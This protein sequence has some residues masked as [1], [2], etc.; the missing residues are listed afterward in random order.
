MCVCFTHWP[1][2]G[3]FF[4]SL[5]RKPS[6]SLESGWIQAPYSSVH[7][8]PKQPLACWMMMVS[9][10][11]WLRIFKL[12]R[13][14]LHRLSD[15]V[16]EKNFS[17]AGLLIGGLYCNSLCVVRCKKIQ[18]KSPRDLILA[19]S[20]RI[21]LLVFESRFPWIFKCMNSSLNCRR[22]TACQVKPRSS[23]NSNSMNLSVMN[24]AF[25]IPLIIAILSHS[26]SHPLFTAGNR[27][28]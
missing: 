24:L 15:F 19:D 7:Y 25:H 17:Y 6:L 4:P 27:V 10:W 20:V 18:L 21:S 26:T 8:L 16:V 9:K 22:D 14:P 3:L 12:I 13:L 23:H 5:I 1:L 28:N 2:L 11:D